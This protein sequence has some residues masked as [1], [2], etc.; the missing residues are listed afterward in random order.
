MVVTKEVLL[1]EIPESKTFRT[2]GLHLSTIIRA[3]AIEGGLLKTELIE[4]LGLVEAHTIVDPIA[5]TRICMGLAWEEWYM[6][7]QLKN[8]VDHPGELH[9]DGIYLTPDGESID[10]VLTAKGPRHI[11]VIHEVKCTYKS[12]RTVGDIYT[13]KELFRQWMWLAQLKAYCK[14]AKA[15]IGYLH[16]LFVCG[17]YTYPIRPVPMVF[18]IE[19]EQAELDKNWDLL[20]EYVQYKL[21]D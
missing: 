1:L 18:R 13:E 17:D 5:I 3:M 4:E 10:Y 14:A 16:V 20:L 8:V 9:L 15:T 21:E 12:V 2:P 6:P 11:T 7:N 19:F